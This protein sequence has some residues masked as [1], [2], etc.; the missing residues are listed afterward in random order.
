MTIN[1]ESLCPLIQVFDMPAALRFY[2]DA[3]GFEVV[4]NSGGTD[5]RFDWVWLKLGGANLM[6]N[7]AYEQHNRPPRSDP[8]RVAAH[9]DT[10]MYVICDDVDRAYSAL[11]QRGLNVKPPTIAPYGM[12][13]LYVSDPDGYEVCFQRPV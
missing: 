4:D 13:Q 6:L 3:L 8:A 5:D 9:A 12:K 1:A 11:L 7:T 10:C 2:R